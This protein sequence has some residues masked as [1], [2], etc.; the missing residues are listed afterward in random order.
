MVGINTRVDRILAGA[1]SDGDD[2]VSK[3]EQIEALIRE[4]GWESV[5][6]CSMSI[7]EDRSRSVGD[8][9][10]LA[11]VFWGA[12]LDHRLVDADRLI[13]VLY[14]RLPHD[15]GSSENNLAWSIACELKG[16]S[17]LSD[18]DPLHDVGVIRELERL[19]ER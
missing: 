6:E 7:L 5:R 17:Y 18:Y 13:A 3:T 14:K 4:F 16:K 19:Q 11:A 10:I 2:D 1:A 12:V 8:W 9:A 15:A